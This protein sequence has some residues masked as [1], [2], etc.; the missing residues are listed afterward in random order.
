MDMTET[1]LDALDQPTVL[2]TEAQ[3]PECSLTDN[4]LPTGQTRSQMTSDTKGSYP[5]PVSTS[6]RKL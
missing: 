1:M 6:C 5:G 4:T 2:S 3:Q